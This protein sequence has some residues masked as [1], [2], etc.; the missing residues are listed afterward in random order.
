M[1]ATEA[2]IQNKS[3]YEIRNSGATYALLND[4]SIP[5]QSREPYVCKL[6]IKIL[7]DYIEKNLSVVLSHFSE[8]I[9]GI[10]HDINTC[11]YEEVNCESGYWLWLNMISSNYIALLGAILILLKKDLFYLSD[12]L[13]Y[14]SLLAFVTI[15]VGV[16]VP[17]MRILFEPCLLY[18]SPSPRD[19]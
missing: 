13:V 15:L 4:E 3:I 6:F 14:I 18:T 5:N 10:T 19:S 17:R 12:M 9:F 16:D 8:F 7:P 1:E 2:K 11:Q